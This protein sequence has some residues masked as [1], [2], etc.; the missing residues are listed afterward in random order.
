M[1][2]LSVLIAAFVALAPVLAAQPISD[3]AFVARIY[4]DLARGDVAAVA[5]VLD[6]HVLW[7]EDARSR[8]AKQHFG[9]GTVARYVLQPQI[10]AGIV[11]VPGT[12]A[13]S[14]GRVMVV[15]STRRGMPGTRRFSPAPFYHVWRV[16]DGR[17]VSVERSANR[18]VDA[19]AIERNT[20]NI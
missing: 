11:D 6:D 1:L 18:P 14:R 10:D 7:I 17:V 16:V 4:A 15:G 13:T 2:R 5:A 12:I 20:P 3:S 8:Q 19:H 9:P